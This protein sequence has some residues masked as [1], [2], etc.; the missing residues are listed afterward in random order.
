MQNYE[1]VRKSYTNI[2]ELAEREAYSMLGKYRAGLES[3][4]NESEKPDIN[5]NFPAVSDSN[6]STF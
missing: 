6:P 2:I 3:S 4:S 1:I 5:P